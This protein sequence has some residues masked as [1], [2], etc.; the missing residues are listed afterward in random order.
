MSPLEK[1]GFLGS[2]ISEW[3]RIIREK[4][5]DLFVFAADV[6]SLGTEVLVGLT[7]NNLNLQET[8]SAVLYLRCSNSYQAAVILAERGLTPQAA[9]LIRAMLE[10]VFILVAIIRSMENAKLYVKIDTLMRK[11]AAKRFRRPDA[12]GVLPEDQ[13]TKHEVEIDLQIKELGA[14][15]VQVRE[16]AERA[17][18]LPYYE[19]VYFVLSDPVHLSPRNLQ[20]HMDVDEEQNVTGMHYGPEIK[21]LEMVLM[22]GADLMLRS[23]E[24]VS[25]L[26]GKDF[27]SR[28][29]SLRDAM[30]K[31]AVP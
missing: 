7:P 22:A 15:K 3:I 31:H 17:D 24:A 8:L 27:S 4:H 21:D 12:S 29:T 6:N 30:K 5:S 16:W 1:H 20:R 23:A 14:R 10:N 2:E 18:M 25:S 13:L 9:I 28:L 11:E 19:V 26:F